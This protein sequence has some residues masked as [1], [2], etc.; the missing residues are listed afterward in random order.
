MQN[1]LKSFRKNQFQNLS[2]LPFWL[3]Y[4]IFREENQKKIE[5]PQRPFFKFFVSCNFFQE[6]KILKTPKPFPLQVL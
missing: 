4:L 6:T 3:I 5:M 2:W 1:L